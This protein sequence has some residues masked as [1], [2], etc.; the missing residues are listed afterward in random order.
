MYRKDAPPPHTVLQPAVAPTLALLGN[1][2]STET[3]AKRSRTKEFL[4][5]CSNNWKETLWIPAT[6]ELGCRG[7]TRAVGW[8]EALEDVLAL[9]NEVSAEGPGTIRLLDQGEHVSP[10]GIRILGFTGWS[11]WSRSADSP[12]SMGYPRLY[13]YTANAQPAPMQPT[14]GHSLSETEME[15]L[16]EELRSDTYSPTILLSHG[17]STPTIATTISDISAYSQSDLLSCYPFTPL[18][19]EMP[20]IVACLSGALGGTVSGVIHGRFHALNAYRSYPSQKVPCAN[21][22][23]D[24]F[25]EYR[26][27]P[28]RC[29]PLWGVN[30]S[31]DDGMPL[32]NY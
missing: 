15:W 6:T 25:Y 19:R 30:Q 1:I 29:T 12:L 28:I 11:A 4:S 8:T 32:T 13:R 21:Y 16:T 23:P 10:E 18:F 17:L 20:Q 22:R 3:S 7:A 2:G 24:A 31:V 14:D 5:Y 27:L 26:R 9:A